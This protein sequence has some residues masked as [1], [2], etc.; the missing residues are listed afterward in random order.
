MCPTYRG[1]IL[2]RCQSHRS[3]RL[4]GAPVLRP[5]YTVRFLLT[6]VACDFCS[7]RCSRHE[8]IVYDFHDIKLPVAFK[9]LKHVS[10]AHDILRVVRDNRKQVV[11]LIYTKRFMS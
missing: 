4:I 1:V 8:K 11:G 5:I 3:G 9:V 10:K 7:A 2:Y 6:I